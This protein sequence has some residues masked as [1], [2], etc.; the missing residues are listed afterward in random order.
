LNTRVFI[1]G[2]NLSFV[3]YKICMKVVRF[4]F[5]WQWRFKLWSSGLWQCTSQPR[6][7]LV[8]KS[9]CTTS[10]QYQRLG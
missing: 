1:T 4:R 3:V 8:Q 6:K 5:P 10:K 9:F 7:Q 2:G